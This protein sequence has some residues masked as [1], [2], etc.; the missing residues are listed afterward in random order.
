MALDTVYAERCGFYFYVE[1]RYAKC[2]Y[3]ERRGA[4]KDDALFEKR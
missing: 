1:S 4:K 2:R 3:T